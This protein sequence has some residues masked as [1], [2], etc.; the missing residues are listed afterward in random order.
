MFLSIYLTVPTN[1]KE[2]LKPPLQAQDPDLAIDPMSRTII[3]HPGSRT[4]RIGRASDAF[5]ISVPNVIARRPLNYVPSKDKGKRRAEPV[6][7]P[8]PFVPPSPPVIVRAQDSTMKNPDDDEDSDADEPVADP[9]IPLDPLT[10]KINSI[11]GDL[12][13]RMRVFKLRGQ[14][15]GNA[16][17]IAYNSQ[18]VPEKTADYNDPNEVDWTDVDS[19]GAKEFYV[20]MKVGS[21]KI[22]DWLFA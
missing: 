3:I 13:T 5:P 20:G 8:A 1:S 18:V 9:S 12:K 14:G 19:P 21:L 16:Q 15:N 10:A 22:Y 17:A 4:L 11:R 7:A 2:P 6:P